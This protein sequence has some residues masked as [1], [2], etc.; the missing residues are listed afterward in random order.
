MDTGEVKFLSLWPRE[1]D[2]SPVHSRQWQQAQAQE[3]T[4]L[5][6]TSV[7][8]HLALSL[9]PLESWVGRP[10][11]QRAWLGSSHAMKG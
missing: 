2:E 6:P 3:E 1:N 4:Q 9:L 11:M 7:G 8:F 5:Q 10:L